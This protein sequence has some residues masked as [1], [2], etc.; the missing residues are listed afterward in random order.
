MERAKL[1]MD[2]LDQGGKKFKLTVDE[3]RE[4]ITEVEVRAAMDAVVER[5]IFHTAAGDIVDPVGARIIT[6]AVQELEI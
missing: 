1:E 3:P 5:N 2:F 6:T 4:D